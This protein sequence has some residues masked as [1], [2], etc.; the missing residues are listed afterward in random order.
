[1]AAVVGIGQAGA[2]TSRRPNPFAAALQDL[3]TVYVLVLG[4]WR[5]SQGRAPWR[6][7][8]RHR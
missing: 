3:G 5:M 7:A 2:V 1:M 8:T 6:P 4:L